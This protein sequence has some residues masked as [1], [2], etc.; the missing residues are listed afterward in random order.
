ME[1]RTTACRRWITKHVSGNCH[2]NSTLVR[3]KQKVSQNC[4]PCGAYETTMHVY[5]SQ[6]E[7][8]TKVWSVEMHKLWEWLRTQDTEQS[9]C[10]TLCSSLLAWQVSG[11]MDHLAIH[12]EGQTLLGWNLVIEGALAA[13]WRR[14]K[15]FGRHGYERKEDKITT[16]I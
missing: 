9:I 5:M 4:L 2:V 6:Q 15:Q 1:K 10:D 8:A 13:N 7:E 16:T 3:W 11:N 14:S 12:G